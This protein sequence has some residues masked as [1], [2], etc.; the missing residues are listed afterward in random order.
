MLLAGDIG[1]TKTTLA[2]CSAEAG[3]RAPLSEATYPSAEYPNLQSLAHDFLSR[4]DLPVERAV[5]GVAGPVVGGRA[6]ITNLSWTMS[7]SELRTALHLSSVTLLNDLQAIATGV[8][9]LEPQDLSTLSAGE[10]VARGTMAVIAPGTGLGEAFLTWDGSR[11]RAHPTEGGHVDFAPLDGLQDG[12]LRYLRERFGH[13]SYER[14]CSGIGLPN[15][16]D[17]LKDSGYAA[18]PSW[19]AEALQAAE[20]RTPVIVEAALSTGRSSTLCA[21]TLDIFVGILGAE[22]GNLAL[23]VLATG[24]AYIGGGIP[25]RILRALQRGRFLEA[26]RAKGRFSG[27]LSRIPIHVILEPKVA[28]LGAACYGLGL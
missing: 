20:D 26:L 28:L 1:G 4:V 9:F 15:I 13:V 11:Y 17:Y 10:P 19:L 14:V 6:E 18:E 22:A 7:E 21:A 3:P 5:F 27:L 12:L 16:Y 23:K 8:P 24:G 25:P 2:V